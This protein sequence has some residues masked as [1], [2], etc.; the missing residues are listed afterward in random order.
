MHRTVKWSHYYFKWKN[1]F[2]Q[3]H[4]CMQVLWLSS[5]PLPTGHLLTPAHPY[6]LLTC[7][8]SYCQFLCSCAY[9]VQVATAAMCSWLLWLRHIHKTEVHSTPS[10]VSSEAFSELWNER[11]GYHIWGAFRYVDQFSILP[12]MKY[13]VCIIQDYYSIEFTTFITPAVL[14]L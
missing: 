3:S 7:F 9:L 12:I 14:S 13:W 2:Y 11:Y 10:A 1:G 4:L 8:L 6:F 5:V